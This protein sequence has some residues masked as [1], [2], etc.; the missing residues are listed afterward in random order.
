MKKITFLTLICLFLLALPVRAGINLLHEF[1]GGN[2]IYRG[3]P[4]SSSVSV[5]L[6]FPFPPMSVN[7]G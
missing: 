3:C 1:A 6:R 5:P 4:G 2:Q 7:A